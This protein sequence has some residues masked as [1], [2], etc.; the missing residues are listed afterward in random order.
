MEVHSTEIMCSKIEA[1]EREE[2][3]MMSCAAARGASLHIIGDFTLH[4]LCEASHKTW[5]VIRT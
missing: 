4:V 2:V 1:R 5:V 3:E